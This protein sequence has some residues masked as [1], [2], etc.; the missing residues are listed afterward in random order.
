MDIGGTVMNGKPENET[1]VTND[2]EFISPKIDYAFKQMMNFRSWTDRVVYYSSRMLSE[3]I[4]KGQNYVDLIKCVSISILDFSIYDKKRYPNYYSSYH[5]REDKDSRI[6]NDLLE[7]HIIELTKI[8]EK[9]IIEAEQDDLLMWA[10][11][12]NSDNKEEMKMLSEKNHGIKAAYDELAALSNDEE[13]RAIYQAREK[14]IMDYNV[15]NP[16]AREE[17]ARKEGI[18]EGI[19]EGIEKGMQTERLNTTIKLLSKK[20]GQL[21]EN[22][23]TEL[24]KLDVVVLEDIIGD[25]FE[26]K[27]LDDVIKKYIN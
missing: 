15:Q 14:A 10:K 12:I 22:F 9:N 3:Q 13:R 6:F 4:N 21:P 2:E 20:F 27:S 17:R 1:A 16:A 18:R 26:Y 25:I 7:F 11:F 19:K 24:S 23:K 5:I 8:S